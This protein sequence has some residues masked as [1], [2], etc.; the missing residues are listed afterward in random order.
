MT[1]RF[2]VRT[3]VSPPAQ[4]SDAQ[5]EMVP[6]GI[7]CPPLGQAPGRPTKEKFYC[8]PQREQQRMAGM[9]A[10]QGGE[11]Q[12]A[13]AGGGGGK[14]GKAPDHDAVMAEWAEMSA[15]RAAAAGAA[16]ASSAHHNGG[17]AQREG[18]PALRRQAARRHLQEAVS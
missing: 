4:L 5:K 17:A 14:G 8:N 1:P 6:E 7:Y 2:S 11:G 18:R 13:A 12:E 15:G 10:K 16:D 3:R 9:G